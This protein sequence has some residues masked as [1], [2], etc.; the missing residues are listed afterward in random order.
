MFFH[1]WDVRKRV[2]RYFS[3]FF[4]PPL[5]SSPYRPSLSLSIP[6]PPEVMDQVL[7]GSDILTYFWCFYVK[8]SLLNIW[9]SRIVTWVLPDQPSRHRKTPKNTK[10]T[11]F[12]RFWHICDAPNVNLT[13]KGMTFLVSFTLKNAVFRCFL[14]VFCMK[15]HVFFDPRQGQVL[16]TDLHGSPVF[17]HFG[18]FCLKNHSKIMKKV[19]ITLILV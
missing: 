12:C 16:K 3:S 14:R 15:K 17:E 10:N 2:I 7:K 11:C 6:W 18:H 13:Q 19:S 1:V 9:L 8:T 4:R 5:A